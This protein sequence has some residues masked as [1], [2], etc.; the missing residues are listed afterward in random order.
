MPCW[1]GGVNTGNW[2]LSL[3][4]A[5]VNCWAVVVFSRA[6]CL[7]LDRTAHDSIDGSGAQFTAFTVQ[8]ATIIL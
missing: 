7:H 5:V 1:G 4:V 8:K 6:L 2:L 3:V